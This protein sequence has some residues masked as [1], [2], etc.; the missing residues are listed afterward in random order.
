MGITKCLQTKENI[1]C[2]AEAAFPQREIPQV[3]ELTE[4]MC[5]VAYKLTYED[6]FQTILKIASPI[7]NGF[8]TNECNM[9]DA[10]VKAM[11]LV[12]KYTDIK[13]AE[14]YAYDTTRTLCEG[15]YF[16]MECMEGVN[17]FTVQESLEEEVKSHLRKEVG[18]VQRKLSQ[19]SGDKF[20]MLGDTEHQFESL[21]E[22]IY[23]MIH[24]VLKDAERRNVEIGVSKEEI[25]GALAKDKECFDEVKTPS[26][27][28]WDMWEGNIFI[29]DGTITGIIDW[30]RA[31]WGEVIMDEPFRY[32]KRN[33]QLLEGFGV[34][35]FSETELRR[36][37]WYD[38]MLYLTM[39]TEVFYREYEDDGQ[40]KW[41]K[42]LFEEVWKE[43]IN[44]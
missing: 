3:E 15:D 11:Q 12:K 34:E 21:Y 23:Y 26:L 41:T 30:E 18:K 24:N 17:W 35:E 1:I 31:M 5:N 8:L 27:V 9:M 6:G 40:Y 2:M 14:V 13:V 28:H 37:F 19:V 16:F 42:M 36:I 29:K 22:F 20:G 39:M 25:L 33:P 43:S 4:G 7:K 32:H 44:S 38:V 10:E